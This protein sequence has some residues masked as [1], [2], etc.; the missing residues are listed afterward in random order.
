MVVFILMTVYEKMPGYFCLGFT[1]GIAQRKNDE[2]R[3]PHFAMR[4]TSSSRLGGTGSK[5][6]GAKAKLASGG[7]SKRVVSVRFQ[8][9]SLFDAMH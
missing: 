1:N 9:E 3:L 4:I 2:L 5:A 6:T 7:E 8:F